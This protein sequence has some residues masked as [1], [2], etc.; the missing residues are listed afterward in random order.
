ML[1]LKPRNKQPQETQASVERRIAELPKGDP[2]AMLHELAALTDELFSGNRVQ[3]AQ[4]YAVADL[5]D[6][7]GRPF[8]RKIA[9][10]YVMGHKQLTRFQDERIWG[11]V[12]A[13]LAQ[14]AQAYRFCLA[15]YVA[16]AQGSRNLERLL[17][18]VAARALRACAGRIKWGGL[19][20]APV[21][22]QQWRELS[23]IYAMAEEGGFAREKIR[24]YR[25]AALDST[26]EQ[27]FL[28]AMML[29]VASPESLAPQ[30]IEVAERLVAHCAPRFVIGSRPAGSMPF[31]VDLRSD[32][33]PHRLPLS[34]RTAPSA[35]A[36]GAGEAVSELRRL[37]DRLDAGRLP[38]AELGLTSEF[39]LEVIRATVRHLARYWDTPL[40]ERRSARLQE[41]SQ[42]TVV[43]DFDQVTA[44]LG[45]LGVSSPFVDGAESWVVENRGQH[46][47]R[48]KVPSPN[49]RWLTVGSLIAFRGADDAV[50]TVGLVRRL[51]RRRD[52]TRH[53]AVESLARGGSMVTLLPRYSRKASIEVLGVLLP[54]SEGVR[55]EVTVLSPP[56]T[57]A[58]ALRVE[59]RAYDRSYM[60]IPMEVLDS[61]PDYQ[62][63]HCRI[64]AAG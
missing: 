31:Y 47:L 41:S 53:V 37:M 21:E 60:L 54:G 25:N 52:D 55:D 16:G 22:G 29:G 28:R 63:A 50:W 30:Q 18:V 57:F 40:P 12:S 38:L 61:G 7:T 48:A 35:R 58:A 44:K 43:H 5:L 32:A 13:Y 51:T 14:V 15:Q 34:G 3:P 8:F 26:V 36:F 9:H 39:S 17:P 19:R 1:G 10:D 59:M 46:G 11:A 20:Y 49:G 24:L 45:A 2:L 56:G 64:H 6:R 42:V 27:E 33:G 4:G 23:A 62:L